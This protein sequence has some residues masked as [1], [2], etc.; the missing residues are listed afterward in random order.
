VAGAGPLALSA[1]K[2]IHTLGL[3]SLLLAPEKKQF[4]MKMEQSHDGTS[5]II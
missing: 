1:G 4:R 3:H 5:K 2:D